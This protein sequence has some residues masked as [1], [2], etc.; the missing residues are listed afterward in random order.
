[1]RLIG[2]KGIEPK[3]LSV[4]FIVEAKTDNFKREE[5]IVKLLPNGI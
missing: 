2:C 3:E 5:V 1:M 4:E